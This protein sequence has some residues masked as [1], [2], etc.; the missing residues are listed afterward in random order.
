[1]Q[2]NNV[3]I[4]VAFAD[5]A[6][7]IT[8]AGAARLTSLRLYFHFHLLPYSVLLLNLCLD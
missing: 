5:T 8:A 6:G 1:M 7:T 3:A 2:I 4:S